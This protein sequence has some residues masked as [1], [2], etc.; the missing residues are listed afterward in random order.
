MWVTPRS[1]G[2]REIA[3]QYTNDELETLVPA[4]L[5]FLHYSLEP[6]HRGE[7]VSLSWFTSASDEGAARGTISFRRF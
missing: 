7:R 4:S 1:A 6:N 5:P 3:P 2:R